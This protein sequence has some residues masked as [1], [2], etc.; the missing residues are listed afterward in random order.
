MKKIYNYQ[1]LTPLFSGVKYNTLYA[2]AVITR[3]VTGDV[4]ADSREMAYVLHPS[5]MCMVMG[6]T[7]KISQ[8]KKLT[9]FLLT[10]P[11][12]QH[13]WL[14]FSSDK[15]AYDIEKLLGENLVIR[16][17]RPYT[18][19]EAASYAHKVVRYRRINYRFNAKRFLSRRDARG[20]YN[21]RPLD[22]ETFYT[23]HGSVVPSHFWD[24]ATDFTR[25]GFGF[26]V[27]EKGEPVSV[28]F[29]A[30]AGRRFMEIGIE[31]AEEYRGRG[32]GRAAAQKMIE[33]CLKRGKMPLWSSLAGD[34]SSK[35]LAQKLGFE[36]V[37]LRSCYRLPAV[38]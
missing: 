2:Q 35:T 23:F 19:T 30:Y 31:T 1:M 20:A 26:T 7:E 10:T 17:S 22:R 14:Q 25:Y 6:E 37:H 12:L 18:S 4:F 24:N 36:E 33:E 11:R 13:H 16:D 3:R 9:D 15:E 32:Y 28:A 21:L 38:C 5:G 27:F 29:A 34:G 8:K